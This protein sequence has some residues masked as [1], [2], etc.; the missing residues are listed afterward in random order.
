MP[1]CAAA[2]I[3]AA[4]KTQPAR[5]IEKTIFFRQLFMRTSFPDPIPVKRM[6][7]A[8]CPTAVKRQRYPAWRSYIEIMHLSIAGA[9]RISVAG[10]AFALTLLPAVGNAQSAGPIKLATIPIDTG[11]EAFYAADQGFFKKNDLDIEIERISN[12]SAITAAVVSGSLDIGFS[13]VISLAIAFQHGVPITLIAPGSVYNTKAPTTVCSVAT[14]SPIKTAKDLNG[15]IFA[16]NGLKN[17]GE[18]APRAWIDRNG[19][20][21]STVKFVE[22]PFPDMAAALAA[23]RI[24]A[25]VLAEP[26]ATVA[27][28]QLRFL[29]KCYD[30]PGNDYLLGAWFVTTA[31]ATA[32]PDLVKKFQQAMRETAVW[33]NANHPATAAIL[34]R[35]A[36]I[37]PAIA[38]SMNRAP[39][40]ERLD[41]AQIQ[42][43]IDVTAKYGSLPAPFPAT[44][45]I[46]K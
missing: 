31:W 13:N 14:G 5:P 22:M 40:A 1:I 26:T 36:K 43:V 12:G 41:P 19:G 44:E 2:G 18:F 25:A 24:D 10:L 29:S 37:D 32:H 4:P 28:S 33:A 46:F 23:G 30:G 27:K 17:I 39:Y 9:L 11:A 6:T 7:P 15:K 16:T 45:L 35:E 20:D 8:G 38:L 34:A 3:A 42:P 21:S